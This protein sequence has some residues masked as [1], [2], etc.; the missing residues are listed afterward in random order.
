M[1]LYQGTH[2]PQFLELAKK[3]EH[4]GNKLYTNIINNDNMAMKLERYHIDG[5]VSEF[6]HVRL[7]SL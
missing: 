3:E 7:R 4:K 1:G 2:N 5:P 6:K